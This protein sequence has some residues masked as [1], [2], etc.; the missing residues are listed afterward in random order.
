MPPITIVFTLLSRLFAIMQYFLH[1]FT[2]SFHKYG[3]WE[4]PDCLQW[5]RLEAH[6]MC[7]WRVA[8]P[9]SNSCFF[10]NNC[11]HHFLSYRSMIILL[12]SWL[13]VCCI[14]QKGKRYSKLSYYVCKTYLQPQI[15]IFTSSWKCF[16]HYYLFYCWATRWWLCAS[17]GVLSAEGRASHV[18]ICPL[19]KLVIMPCVLLMPSTKGVYA[20]LHWVMVQFSNSTLGSDNRID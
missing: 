10:D 19:Y 9:K 13:S 8:V 1:I 12:W 16:S 4:K 11:F 2:S 17:R 18:E 15:V 7:G 5:Q 20:R 3:F 14:L 6:H